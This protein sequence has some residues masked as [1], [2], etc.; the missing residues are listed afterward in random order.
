MHLGQYWKDF[1]LKG[2]NEMGVTLLCHRLEASVI[3]ETGYC[4]FKK[5]E[6]CIVR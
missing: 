3:Q 4:R 1:E 2:K 6:S 5:A